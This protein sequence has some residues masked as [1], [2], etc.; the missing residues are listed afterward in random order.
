M[1]GINSFRNRI[2]HHE[3]IF[4]RQPENKLQLILEILGDINT[5]KK[6]WVEKYDR[7][8]QV[9]LMRPPNDDDLRF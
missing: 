6:A 8:Y 5:E 1:A 2:A 9:L 7:V 4:D 3:P